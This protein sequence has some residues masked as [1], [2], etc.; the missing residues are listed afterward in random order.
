MDREA[1]HAA[2]HGDAKN[3]TQPKDWTELPISGN[4]VVICADDEKTYY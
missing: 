4:K 3:Q 2:N 1:W